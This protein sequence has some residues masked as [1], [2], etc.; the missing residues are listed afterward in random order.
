M[1]DL[2]GT[3]HTNCQVLVHGGRDVAH[4]NSWFLAFVEQPLLCWAFSADVITQG[5]V[6]FDAENMTPE[7]GDDESFAVMTSHHMYECFFAIKLLQNVTLDETLWTQIP[8]DQR[9]PVQQ[10]CRVSNPQ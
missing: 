4:A 10:V 1:S 6:R 8:D 2:Y 9:G 7:H 5:H 3:F